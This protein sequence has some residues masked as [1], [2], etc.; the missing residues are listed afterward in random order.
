MNDQ[1]FNQAALV[2]VFCALLAMFV[3]WCFYP[4]FRDLHVGEPFV[5]ANQFIPGKN[6][7]EQGFLELKFNADY[8]IGDKGYHPFFYTHNPPLSEIL[9]GIYQ[10]IG[11]EEIQWQ[12]LIC[13][14]WTF[15][16]LIFF[17]LLIKDLLGAKIA[18]VS[19]IV[20]VTNPYFIFW[21]DNLFSSHQWFFVYASCY[22]VLR[23][24]VDEKRW[25]III[26]WML[27]FLAA[28]SNYELIPFIS[29]FIVGIKIFNIRKINIKTLVI[30][31]LAPISAFILRNLLVIWALGFSFWYKDIIEIVLHRS[32]GIK[33]GLSDIYNKFPVIMWDAEANLPNNY[34]WL[35]CRRLEELYGYGWIILTTIVF[36]IYIFFKKRLSRQ[37]IHIMQVLVIFFIMG[38]IWYLFLPQ[39][40]WVHFHSSTMLLILPFTSILWSSFFVYFIKKIKSKILTEIFTIAG[41]ILII[42]SRIDS[43]IMPKPFPG[44]NRLV[45]YQGKVFASNAIPT[46]IEYYTNA[47]AAFCGYDYQLNNLLE[48]KG[49]FFLN[50]Q[51]GKKALPVCEYFFSFDNWKR[52][53]LRKEFKLI[54]E[55]DRYAIYKILQKGQR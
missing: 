53:R 33:T 25:Q 46:L 28:F 36:I 49:Y 4:Q 34:L 12:R 5:D 41:V 9:N 18:L 37:T 39:H 44:I 8:A 2:V 47:P 31:L 15:F 42:F 13:M 22:Y 17:Y 23:Y 32:F 16:S 54:E 20:T 48:G 19:L 45:E 27:F 29:I 26:S 55:G 6:F 24:L 38:F 11:L 43:F 50:A 30:F 10:I 1:K 52:Q 14:V 35:L 40:T 51:Q 3:N 21:G 7:K